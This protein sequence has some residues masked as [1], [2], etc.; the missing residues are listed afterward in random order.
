MGKNQRFLFLIHYLDIADPNGVELGIRNRGP[1]K[2]F[3]QGVCSVEV[4]DSSIARGIG[5]RKRKKKRRT[6]DREWE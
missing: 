3:C 1:V 2:L 5:G 4:T 6:F